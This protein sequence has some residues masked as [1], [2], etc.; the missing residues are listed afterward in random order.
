[1]VRV[2]HHDMTLR[3][4]LANAVENQSGAGR[5]AS[6]RRAEQREVL[7]EHG[8]DIKAGADVLGRVDGTDLDRAAAVRGVDLPQILGRRRIDQCGGNRVPR[9]A[10]AK[11]VDFT[12]QL[13]FLAFAQKIDVGENAVLAASVL[14]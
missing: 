11:R 14:L 4:A 6:A 10:A 13:L 1:A 2:D 3:R 7:A 12:G 9:H 5:L 8:V